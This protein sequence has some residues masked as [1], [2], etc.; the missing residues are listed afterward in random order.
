MII[1]SIIITDKAGLSLMLVPKY[2]K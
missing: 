2:F 1:E